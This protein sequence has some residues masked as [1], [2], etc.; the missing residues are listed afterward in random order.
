MLLVLGGLSAVPPLSFDMYLPALPQVADSLGVP[1]AQIQLT[2]SACL[3]GLAFGQLFGGPVSDSL[4]RR[5]PL[6]V[7]I[8]GYAFF[9]LAC[10]FAP[11]APALVVLRFAQGLLGGVAVVIARAVVRDREEGAA[12]ARVFSLLMLVSGIAPIAAPLF[13]G[14]LD[15]RD[16]LAGNLRRVVTAR[17]G[18]LLAVTVILPET[19]APDDRHSG[20]IG[21]TLHRGEAGRPASALSWVTR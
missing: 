15:Q 3:L 10:A 8:G 19:L 16:V 1:E 13:G 18:R 7:G 12:A 2:L 20:G 6:L 9:S 4:G 17:S 5:R 21:Q 11:T 14:L